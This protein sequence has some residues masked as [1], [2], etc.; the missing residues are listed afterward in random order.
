[1]DA[2]RGELRAT[3]RD[4]DA[5]TT[6]LDGQ[7]AIGLFQVRFV[8]AAR[9]AQNFIVIIRLEIWYHDGLYVLLG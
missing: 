4:V 3:I 8:G 2:I 7:L 6:Y 5:L 1:M 9:N